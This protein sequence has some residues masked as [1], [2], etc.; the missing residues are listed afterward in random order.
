MRIFQKVITGKQ[1]LEDRCHVYVSHYEGWYIYIYLFSRFTL[2]FML[3]YFSMWMQHMNS[4]FAKQFKSNVFLMDLHLFCTFMIHMYDHNLTFWPAFA[5][6]YQTAVLRLVPLAGK[7]LLFAGISLE[8]EW[9]TTIDRHCTHSSAFLPPLGFRI[10]DWSPV[11]ISNA[12]GMFLAPRLTFTLR[13]W[14]TSM[15]VTSLSS[16]CNKHTYI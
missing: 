3:F 4:E 10:S 6:Y 14:L 16:F 7:E 2:M 1:Y 11:K 5:T 12:F 9:A 15:G 13:I 8:C